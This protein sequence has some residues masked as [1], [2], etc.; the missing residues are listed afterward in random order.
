[1]REVSDSGEL[2]P[3]VRWVTQFVAERE[4]TFAELDEVGCPP[5]AAL[6]Y[7]SFLMTGSISILRQDL[8]DEQ[9]LAA[10]REVGGV[11]IRRTSRRSA[12]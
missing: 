9:A 10:V 2:E 8:D 12:V 4:I 3:I 5:V 11:Y 6:A 1:M 7:V